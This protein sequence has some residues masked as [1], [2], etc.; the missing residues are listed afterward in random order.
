MSEPLPNDYAQLIDE[1]ALLLQESKLYHAKKQRLTDTRTSAL[2]LSDLDSLLLDALGKLQH[3]RKRVQAST[4]RVVVTFVGLGNVGKSTLLNALLGSDIAPR[5]NG[6]CTAAP[7][8]FCYGSSIRV[9]SIHAGKL[10]RRQQYPNDY[11]ALRD[12][13]SQLADEEEMAGSARPTRVEV[14]LPLPLL[15]SGLVIA[16]TP[17]FG[18]A[19]HGDAN[20]SH[21]AALREYLLTEAT[22]VFWVVLAEQG[23]GKSEKA[24]Y[25]SMFAEVCDD[26]LV[27]GSE[28]WDADERK[29][30]RDRFKPLLSSGSSKK[31]PLFHFVSGLRGLDAR[32]QGDVDALELAGIPSLE[33]RV[34]QMAEGP[35][36]VAAANAGLLQLA[37]DLRYWL[38]AIR[39]AQGRRID[40][41]WRRDSFSRWRAVKTPLPI[42]ATITEALRSPSS[43]ARGC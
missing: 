34:R 35:G 13:L 41:W 27:T 18:S 38:L 8:E 20:G 40:P 15:Q 36:R 37:E 5:R 42:H 24:M 12:C 7:I 25:D 31:S 39:D 3:L 32:K 33:A 26:V 19:Q 11:A 21:D 6:P 1:M 4:D 16:D 17:G 22:Q 10:E 29:R 14:Q 9:V 2:S 28:D 23:I 30:F 43:A